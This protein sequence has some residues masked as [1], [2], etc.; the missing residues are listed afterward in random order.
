MGSARSKVEL[1]KSELRE[2]VATST[3]D[4]SELLVLFDHFKAISASETDD[5]LIDLSEFSRALGL[6]KNLFSRRIFRL[7]DENG[8]GVINFK[9][10]VIGLSIFSPKGSTADKEDFSFRFFDSD[11][12]GYISRE[13]L[14]EVLRASISEHGQLAISEEQIEALL[15]STFEEVDLNGD[16]RIDKAEYKLMLKKH[17]SILDQMTI[18]AQEGSEFS[19]IEI[20]TKKYSLK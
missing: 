6:T 9:E 12:D 18:G 19:K 17:K 7:F 20:K 13:E 8:D 2:L 10:F 11:G 3:F 4:E 5:G 16:G 14:D 15:D 1:S